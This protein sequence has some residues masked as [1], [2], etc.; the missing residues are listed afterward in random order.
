MAA[1]SASAAFSRVFP[2][3]GFVGF[4]AAGL[5]SAAGWVRLLLGAVDSSALM[6]QSCPARFWK[7]SWARSASSMLVF[8]G[9]TVSCQVLPCPTRLSRSATPA[10]STHWIHHPIR[11]PCHSLEG[12][13]GSRRPRLLPDLRG[14]ASDGDG[15]TAFRRTSPPRHGTRRFLC[16]QAASTSRSLRG[17]RTPRPIRVYWSTRRKRMK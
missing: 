17:R 5:P 11:L 1:I 2:R 10:C 15:V 13:T 3:G 7:S 14:D 8:G 4:T 9:V 16:R 6:G 12:G